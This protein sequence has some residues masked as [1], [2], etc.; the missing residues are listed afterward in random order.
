MF[1]TGR[2]YAGVWARA[3]AFSYDLLAIALYLAVVL[4]VAAAVQ[5]YAPAFAARLAASAAGQLAGFL[6]F[7]LPMVL[8]FALQEASSRQASWGKHR[9]GLRVAAVDARRVRFLRALWRNALKFAP[10]EIAHGCAWR[11]WY[12]ATGT[13]PGVEAGLILVV[14]LAAANLACA[15]LTP[16]R[17]ALYDLLSGT[18]VVRE[19][20]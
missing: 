4:C 7:T 20:G 9:C 3:R 1:S 11:L 8:Y 14:A 15:A 10:L 2:G 13:G 12:G 6:S 5:A 19:R 18:M 17:Q 16:K